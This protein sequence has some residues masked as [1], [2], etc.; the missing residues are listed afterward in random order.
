MLTAAGKGP[1]VIWCYNLRAASRV[2]RYEAKHWTEQQPILSPI[3]GFVAQPWHLAK[4]FAESSIA[5]TEAMYS[6][7]ES[8]L[9]GS[10]FGLQPLHTSCTSLSGSLTLPLYT[11]PKLFFSICLSL[12]IFFFFSFLFLPQIT[13]CL[14]FF[15][16]LLTNIL[17]ER[18]PQQWGI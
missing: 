18:F 3:Q 12:L 5:P 9:S 7:L 4:V 11:L 6:H 1:P 2:T 8:R 17:E 15:Q 14:S 10:L 13:S 16:I